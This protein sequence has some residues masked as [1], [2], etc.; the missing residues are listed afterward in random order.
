MNKLVILAVAALATPLAAHAAGDS[1]TVRAEGSTSVQVAPG[2]MIYSGSSRL[3]SVYR[4]DSQGNPQVVLD[5]KLVTIPA[6]T[7]SN[8]DGKLT[9][10][11]TKKDIN[12]SQ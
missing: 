11:L 6:Q 12:K 7:L 1:S 3:A 2:K 10:S 4:V 9:T 5:G 8:V